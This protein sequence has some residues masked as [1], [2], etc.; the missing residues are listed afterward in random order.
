M[1]LTERQRNLLLDAIASR[2]PAPAS[3]SAAA[4]VVAT[5]AAL[6]VKVA[7]FSSKKWTGAPPA[8]RRARELRQRAEKL[9]HDDA[10]AYLEYLTKRRLGIDADEARAQTVNVPLEIARTAHQ[11]TVLAHELATKGNANLRADAVAAAI[12]AGSAIDCTVMLVEVNLG[13]AVRD[14]RLVEARKIARGASGSVRRLG[15]L[16]LAGGLDR[17]PARSAGSRR[18]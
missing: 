6:L 3:G 18:R 7:I 14:P 9:I 12:L 5:A 8:G 16:S 15:A 10:V 2:A 13:V 1:A 11:V 4:L 17:A